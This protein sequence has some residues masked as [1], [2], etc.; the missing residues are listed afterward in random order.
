MIQHP[1][2]T[3]AYAKLREEL[4]H[5][6][7]ALRDQRE[8]VAELRRSLPLDT[9]PEDPVFEGL[10]DG[11]K[12]AVQ[13]SDLFADREKPL[14]LMHF[15]F[16]GTVENP[17]PMCTMWADG[18]NA[19]MQHLEPR[20]NFAVIVAGDV[21]A[22]SGYAGSRGWTNLRIV[23]AKNSSLKRDLGFETP[24]GGQLPGVSVYELGPEG[25]PVHFYSRSA[26]FG[27]AGFR[28]MDLLSPVWNFFDLTR[29]GRGDFMPQKQYA[30]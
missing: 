21:A 2:E 15:M 8:R 10:V 6:E 30:G 18:Y 11:K 20:A 1:A 4:C 9:P 12:V 29:E 14:I 7:V 27:E 13:L 24:D 3:E 22:F 19:V 28:G 25:E 23:S 16:G 17:C 5:A 26:F